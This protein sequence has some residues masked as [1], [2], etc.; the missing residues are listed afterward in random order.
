[1]ACGLR[2]AGSD[3]TG[4]GAGMRAASALERLGGVGS[5]PELLDL[6]PRHE[7]VRALRAREIVR[8]TRGRYA[9]P[10]ADRAR[11]VAARLNG[12]LALRSAAIEHGWPVKLRPPIPEVAVPRNR[13][14]TGR[15]GARLVWVNGLDPSLR[16][17][18]P[19]ETVLACARSLPFDEALTIADAGLRS[20][21]VSRT[22]LVEAADLAR[23]AGAARIRKVGRLADAKAANPFESVLRAITIEAG[24]R[25]EPQH[26]VEVSGMTLH[27]DL[28]DADSG[29]ILEADSWE[30][31]T[32]RGAHQRDCW[33][34]NEFVAEGWVVL[35]F[36]WWH[37]M[38]QPDYVHE[39]LSRV[40]GQPLGR[41][42]VAQEL[43]K[44]A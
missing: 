20:A 11:R 2:D 17:T 36:T 16:A 37:V 38:E 5:V 28:A 43:R 4:E 27:P 10:D 13:K 44:P 3:R 39:V 21:L 30:F 14:V 18:P 9:L 26:P 35:R 12:V 19:L 25:F 29:V 31:H 33:R 22:E 23:G 7:V 1:M 6:S 8:L 42:E 15:R 32:G 24:L 34:Y 41:A 40:Y